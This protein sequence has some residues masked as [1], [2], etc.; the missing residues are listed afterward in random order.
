MISRTNNNEKYRSSN[1]LLPIYNNSKEGNYVINNNK[2]NKRYLSKMIKK[3]K[4]VLIY[5]YLLLTSIW[6]Y[7]MTYYEVNYVNTT[8]SKC[9]NKN[10]NDNNVDILVFGDVQI[11][12]KH[13]YPGRPNIINW[14][15]MKVL[16]N[17][18]VKNWIATQKIIKPDYNLF[19][20]DL[21]DGGRYWE[22]SYWYNE[23]ERFQKI[24][25]QI[26]KGCKNIFNLPGNHDIGFGETVL[27]ESLERF[28]QNFGSTNTRIEILGTSTVIYIIDTISLSDTDSPEIQGVVLDYLNE[29]S[30]HHFKSKDEKRILVTHVPLFRN[31]NIQTCGPHRESK[32]PFPIMQGDQYQTVISAELSELVLNSVKPDLVLSGDDHDYCEIEHTYNDG[33]NNVVEIT[34]K[35]AAMNM[36]IKKPELTYLT[37]S[38]QNEISFQQC[39]LPDPY[40]PFIT[41]TL[42]III[43]IA[44]IA[45]I[46]FFNNDITETSETQNNRKLE[47]LAIYG[48]K[49][50]MKQIIDS[51]KFKL[52]LFAYRIIVIS[53]VV[54]FFYIG[55]Y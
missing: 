15:T 27:K 8:I 29:I 40:K 22:D 45:Y 13:S 24:F 52:G 18:H 39:S 44:W 7:V 1:L 25:P 14:L 46:T 2:Y 36:G 3:N 42:L 9:N 35:S 53:I 4:N 37:I 49:K 17:Y 55:Y 21:F 41:Y 31:P 28:N 11:M 32:K 26:N 19:M 23:Y 48:D 51:K 50:K 54:I 47:K 43:S 33:E 20:G 10:L 16:D 34:T 6:L 38:P 5:V 12:D 30:T